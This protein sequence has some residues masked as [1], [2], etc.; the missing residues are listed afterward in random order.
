[1]GRSGDRSI[2]PEQPYGSGQLV[3]GIEAILRLVLTCANVNIGRQWALV[4]EAIDSIPIIRLAK[5]VD[6]TQVIAQ[7]LVI[8]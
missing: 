6:V 8:D 3:R 5:M 1:M 2:R 4:R 7:C